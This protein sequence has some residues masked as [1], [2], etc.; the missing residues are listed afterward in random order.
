MKKLFMTMVLLSGLVSAS[1]QV[2]EPVLLPNGWKLTPAGKHLQLGDLPLNMAVSPNKKWLA[3][4]NNGYG[5]QCIKLFDVKSE[6]ETDDYTIAKSWY[7]ICFSK[8][9]KQLFASAGNDNQVK[10]YD[11]NAKGKLA[12]ADSIVMGKSWDEE[13]IS[14]S[15]IAEIGRAHV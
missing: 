8:D 15:G 5:R 10:I 3:V 2:A 9:G 12:L 14:P 13:R 4:T 6:Q 7:G 1:A 11:V